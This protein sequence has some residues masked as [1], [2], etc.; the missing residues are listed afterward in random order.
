MRQ[1]LELRFPVL[2]ALRTSDRFR[3]TPDYQER[4]RFDA[5]ERML[6]PEWRYHNKPEG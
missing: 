1:E 4:A 2:L 6:E 3:C 5:E